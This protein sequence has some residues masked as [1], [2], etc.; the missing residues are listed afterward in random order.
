MKGLEVLEILD[1]L[2][3]CAYAMKDLPMS[4]WSDLA[5]NE[6]ELDLKIMDWV[7]TIKLELLKGKQALTELKAIKETKSSE[8]MESLERIDK[9]YATIEHEDFK[10]CFNTIKQ[11]LLKAQEQEKKLK[12]LEIVDKKRVNIH[13]FKWCVF[14]KYYVNYYNLHFCDEDDQFLNEQEFDLLKEVFCNDIS[15]RS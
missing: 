11:A 4:N 7:E 12:A 15:N 5:E 1:K 3:E 13:K 2:E 8:A 10:I 14:K 9:E 6:F